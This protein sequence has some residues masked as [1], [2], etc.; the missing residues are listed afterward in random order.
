MKKKKICKI[1]FAKR[2]KKSFFIQLK[3]NMCKILVIAF[4]NKK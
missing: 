1:A 3:K 4:V 2:K